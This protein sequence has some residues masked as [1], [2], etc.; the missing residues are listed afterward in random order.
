[1]PMRPPDLALENWL[2]TRALPT[3]TYKRLY[4]AVD[5]AAT[6]LFNSPGCTSTHS[7]PADKQTLFLNI[8]RLRTEQTQVLPSLKEIKHTR[9]VTVQS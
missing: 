1:M 2:H 3:R 7:L 6:A 4:H 8:R 9:S 5:L